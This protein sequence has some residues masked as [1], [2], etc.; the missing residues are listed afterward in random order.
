MDFCRQKKIG[1]RKRRK[2]MIKRKEKEKR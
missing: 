1:K 2:K